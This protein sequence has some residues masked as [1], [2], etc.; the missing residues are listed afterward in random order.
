MSGGTVEPG[1]AMSR[2]QFLIGAGAVAAEV[3]LLTSC[4]AGSSAIVSRPPATTTPLHPAPTTTPSI[5]VKQPLEALVPPL[6]RFIRAG[7]ATQPWVALTVD[8]IFG[9][10]GVN[11]LAALLDVAKARNVQLTFFPTGGA[12]EAHLK[13]NRQDVWRRALSEG[14]EIGNHGYTHRAFN[15]LSDQELRAELTNTQQMLNRVLGPDVSYTMRLA[16]PPGGAGGFVNGGDPRIMAVLT[17]LGYSMVMWTI[18]SNNTG[19]NL[20]FP[21]KIVNNA[22]NGSIVLLHFTTFPVANYPGLIDR[23]R[24]ER[25]LEPTNVS[26][27][28]G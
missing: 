8:D 14:H 15:G 9:T 1:V 17:Q 16:R 5:A 19:A 26:G 21:Y 22:A 20:P 13:A 23:L 27:L 7:P 6:P 12:L 28:F 11:D 4:T 18:D 10:A 3:A 24:N 2:R 25:H